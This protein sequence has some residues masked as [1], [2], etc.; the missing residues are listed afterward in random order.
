[1]KH[2]N[3]EELQAY[4]QRWKTVNEREIEE[5]RAMT[6]EEKFLQLN[7]MYNFAKAM[8]ILP[9]DSENEEEVWARW[10]TLRNKLV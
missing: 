10:N 5:L 1:M 4:V 8:G 7:S 2:I 3:P 6:E 9:K